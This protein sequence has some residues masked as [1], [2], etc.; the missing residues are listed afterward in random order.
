MLQRVVEMIRLIIISLM[1][2]LSAIAAKDPVASTNKPPAAIKIKERKAEHS[3]NKITI[4]ARDK[5]S[6]KEADFKT[7]RVIPFM[8]ANNR[9]A[10]KTT[11]KKEGKAQ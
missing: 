2:S 6:K 3:E 8:F 11:P 1:F 10:K 5:G 9:K 4:K 7:E